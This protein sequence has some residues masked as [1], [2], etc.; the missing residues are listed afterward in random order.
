MTLDG[1]SFLVVL[2]KKNQL[3]KFEALI[4]FKSFM[5]CVA[6]GKV[7]RGVVQNGR[8]LRKEELSEGGINKRK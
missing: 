2:K 5:N 7:L 8:L 3:T 4:G 6:S 1:S